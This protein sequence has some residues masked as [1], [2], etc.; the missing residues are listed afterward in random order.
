M[1]T[2]PWTHHVRTDEAPLVRYRVVD[3]FATASVVENRLHALEILGYRV[4]YIIPGNRE[5]GPRVL[6][7]LSADARGD[8]RP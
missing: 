4:L 3:T 7:E 5:L 2:A 6:M 8:G 1:D